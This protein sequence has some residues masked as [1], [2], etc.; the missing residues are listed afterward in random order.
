MERPRLM[1]RLW[2]PGMGGD[3]LLFIARPDEA[4]REVFDASTREQGIQ[5]STGLAMFPLVNWH[6]TLSDR[7]IDTPDTR[8]LLRRAGDGIQLR[9]FTLALDRLRISPNERQSANVELCCSQDV[10]GLKQLIV[11]LKAAIAGQDLLT[12]R[13]GH[14]PHVTL[15]YRH[16]TDVKRQQSHP[17]RTIAWAIDSFELVVGSGDPYRYQTLARWALA[18]SKPPTLQSSLF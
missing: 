6:Q 2:S 7:F 15:S 10:D 17:I 3:R 14:R 12:T 4:M 8:D 5:A 18:P 13:S 11:A 16:H 1:D 9:G